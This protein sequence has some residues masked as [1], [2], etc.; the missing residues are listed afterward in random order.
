MSVGLLLI[1]VLALPFIGS[2]IAAGLPR[3]ARTTAAILSWGVALANVICLAALWP[4]FQDGEVIRQEIDW[5]P[6]LGVSLVLRLD[7]LSWL[8]SALILGS[9]R[10]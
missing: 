5:L 4:A 1:V 7:G 3:N 9:A 6:A 8:F 10:S 2:V